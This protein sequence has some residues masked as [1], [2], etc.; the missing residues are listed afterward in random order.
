MGGARTRIS[1]AVEGAEDDERAEDN[2]DIENGDEDGGHRWQ[3]R[4]VGRGQ[5]VGGREA[6]VR[7]AGKLAVTRITL[8]TIS[9]RS[10]RSRGSWRA[11]VRR[12][13]PNRVAGKGRVCA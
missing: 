13:L 7:S 6:R 2:K 1:S 9:S 11:L 5:A 10:S 12:L 3:R 8:Y 4:G